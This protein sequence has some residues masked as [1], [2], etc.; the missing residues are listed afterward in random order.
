MEVVFELKQPG[1]NP[2]QQFYTVFEAIGKTFQAISHSKE[3]GVGVKHLSGPIGIIGGWWYEFAHGG[4]LRGI[5]FA[6]ML[7]L[8]L[9]VINLMPLPVLDGGHIMFSLIEWIRRKP[10]SPRVMQPISL[11]FVVLI[12]SLFLYITYF[13][14]SRFVSSHLRSSPKPA[15]SQTVPAQP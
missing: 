8:N 5:S 3:T 12:V 9:A 10:L 1:P 14:L 4:I 6:I 15:P 11:G 7:N 13:D 2:V